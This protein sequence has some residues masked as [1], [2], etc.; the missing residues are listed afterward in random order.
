MIKNL[1][2]MKKIGT[3]RPDKTLLYPMQKITRIKKRR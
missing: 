1:N 3:Q 2:I